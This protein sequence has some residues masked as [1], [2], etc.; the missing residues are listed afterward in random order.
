MEHFRSGMPQAHP[1][2]AACRK[3]DGVI[4]HRTIY[5]IMRKKIIKSKN[6]SKAQKSNIAR[7]YVEPCSTSLIVSLIV[8]FS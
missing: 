8:S 4:A 6:L 1:V 5:T 2:F 3:I 7:E